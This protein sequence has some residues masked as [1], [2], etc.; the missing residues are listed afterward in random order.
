MINGQK[1]MGEQLTALDSAI[2]LLTAMSV[3]H[4]SPSGTASTGVGSQPSQTKASVAPRSTTVQWIRLL[5]LV[6]L[7]HLFPRL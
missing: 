1:G 7:I 3:Q 2:A 4:A 6:A 5:S